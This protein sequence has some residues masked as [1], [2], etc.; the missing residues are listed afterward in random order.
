MTHVYSDHIVRNQSLPVPLSKNSL[1]LVTIVTLSLYLDHFYFAKSHD[2]VLQCNLCVKIIP[3]TDNRCAICNVNPVTLYFIPLPE[4]AS[5][6]ICGKFFRHL[7]EKEKDEN[8]I[9][10]PRPSCKYLQRMTR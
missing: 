7:R 9:S 1:V 6:W 4:P 2:N 8:H 10:M 5:S 3:L